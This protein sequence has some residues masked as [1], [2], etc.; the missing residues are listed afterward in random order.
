[1]PLQVLPQK[2]RPVAAGP[3]ADAEEVWGHAGLKK[4][5]QRRN[6]LENLAQRALNQVAGSY[7]HE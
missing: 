3:V 4:H 1:M 6:Q 2:T 7:V 5:H